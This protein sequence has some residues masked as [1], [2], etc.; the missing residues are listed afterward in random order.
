MNYRSNLPAVLVLLIGLEILVS[1]STQSAKEEK[2]SDHI[3]VDTSFQFSKNDSLILINSF[4]GDSLTKRFDTIRIAKSTYFLY[5][6]DLLLTKQELVKKLLDNFS[7]KSIQDVLYD[8]KESGIKEEAEQ[9]DLITGYDMA[10]HDTIKWERFPIKYCIDKTSFNIVSGGYDSVKRNFLE[11]TAEWEKLCK[12]KFIYVEGADRYNSSL[13][14]T[15]DFVVTYIPYNI[16][17]FIATSFFPNDPIEKRKLYVFLKYWLTGYDK[18]GI[19]RHEIGH[20]LGF[21]HEHSSQ[22][23]QVPDDCRYYYPE[24]PGN[25]LPLTYYDKLSVMHYFCG[26]AGTRMMNFSRL[27]TFGTQTIY[28][29]P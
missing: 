29:K 19:F 4:S 20:I 8:Q 17:G 2:S 5:Q 21:K 26:D 1:C 23:E 18:I 6:G 9:L 15:V 12:V 24:L 10:T 11:A 7:K 14:A 16:K 25:G 22:S 27:D 3:V 13:R 28:G